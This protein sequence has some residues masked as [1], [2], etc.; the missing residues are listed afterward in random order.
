MVACGSK[1]GFV[2]GSVQLWKRTA[3]DGVISADYHCDIDYEGFKKWLESW[4]PNLP[5]GS[6]IVCVELLGG[7][8]VWFR[9][10]CKI[11]SLTRG[12]Y[13]I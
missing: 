8:S 6:V 10:F 11:F 1:D 7:R 3:K 12:F 9:L 2:E 5:P 13:C 4:L